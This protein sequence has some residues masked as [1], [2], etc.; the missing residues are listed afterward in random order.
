MPMDRFLIA[1]FNTGLQT[2]TKPWLIMEDAFDYLQ[3]A[4]VFR[5]RLRKRF[6][7]QLMGTTQ[8]SSRLRTSLASGGAGIGITDA[9][10]NAVG[11]VRT[12]L[13]DPTLPLGIGQAFSIGTEFFTVVDA[14][15][16]LQAM[17]DTGGAV[18]ALFNTATGDFNFTGADSPLTTIFFYPALPVMGITQY[19]INAVN[20][21]PTYAFDTRYAYLFSAGAWNRS[22][23]AQ[24]NGND[25]DYFW[26]SNWQ[27]VAGTQ[28]LFV[29]N[30]NFTAPVPG[31]NDDPIW[32]FD[33]ATWTARSG[34]NA[35]YFRPNGGA[36]QTGPYVKTA[37]IIVVFK[38]RLVLLNTVENDNS[39]GAGVNT[40]FVNR[41]RYCFYGS[42]FA[43]NAWY[44]KN[45][46]DAAGNVASGGG[47]VDAA[48]EEQ[49]ISAEFI[50]DRLIVYFERSTWELVYT[51]NQVLPFVWQKI[52][53]ELG[54]M[55]TFSIV[56]F[57]KA[58]LAIGQTGV[59]ACNGA[60]VARV[61]EKI[62]DSVFEFETDNDGPQRTA[63][64][65]DYYT[66]LV[67][68]AFV[69]DLKQP[70]QKFP[71]QVLIYNYKNGSWALFDDCITTFGYFEQANDMTW[72]SSVPI[73]WQ[74]AGWSWKSKVVQANQRNI[75][76]GTPEGFVLILNPEQS[77]N[78]PSMQIT[79]MA[80]AAT[81]IVTLTIINH[82]LTSQ[83][84]EF[85]YDNDFILIENV[86]GDAGTMAFLNGGIFNIDS[87]IDAN[88]VTINT[89]GGLVAGTYN[90]GGTAS[91]VSNVQIRS[92]QWNPYVGQDRGF[93]LA[94]IDFA[95]ERTEFGQITVD[96]YPSASDVGM[97]QEGVN[98]GSIMGN[99]ILE[100]TPY[101]PTL[102]PFEE[103]QEILHHPIFFQTSGEF[104]QIG[105][106]F[107]LDQ[108]LNPNI[109]LSD[110]EIHGLTLYTQP[111]SARL[112]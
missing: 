31:A 48:S 100:T 73:I 76:M 49:I 21:H 52:N 36:I 94:K 86:V 95:V 35:F 108:M 45:Q 32:T 39:G 105:M 29:T 57:D 80:F 81:G 6:G 22:G 27:G 93:Y 19:E 102:Y 20:N 8:L 72:A 33:G 68:W 78:A 41:A 101:D 90:G 59:H 43:V 71:N 85:D 5:G 111:T 3:N 46:T 62:P 13:G 75:L 63:G 47:F 74:Q 11:N 12:I 53:T 2:D 106:S 55:S 96:Y 34:A 15:P 61:D 69:D 50:K 24:W 88:T 37:R 58:V 9:G 51:N 14:N 10:G 104:I 17:L 99:G 66:E 109:S 97:I 23:T 91:R 84:I 70:T 56:P 77:R 42:P 67:Y 28:V 92:K 7:S 54:A 26:A 60:N 107:N 112:Q 89:F 16:G 83:P 110:L 30:F 18:L 87:V 38:N 25:L 4:Y 103:F 1:P 40:N 82:N 44:E 98:S 79:N 64:I 65:R